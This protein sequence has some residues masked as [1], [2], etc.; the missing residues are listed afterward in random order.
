MGCEGREIALPTAARAV[1]QRERRPIED[2]RLEEVERGPSVRGK[3]RRRRCRLHRLQ[4]VGS[5]ASALPSR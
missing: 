1:D 3:P 5:V 4:P 2:P